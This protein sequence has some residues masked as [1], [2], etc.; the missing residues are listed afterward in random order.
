MTV[1]TQLR[2]VDQWWPL[3]PEDDKEKSS[4]EGKPKITIHTG[5]F[6]HRQGRKKGKTAK[7]KAKGKSKPKKDK[8]ASGSKV[9]TKAKRRKRLS[10][11]KKAAA[12][13]PEKVENFTRKGTGRSLVKQVMARARKLDESKFGDKRLFDPKTDT[14]RLAIG[15]CQG[16]PWSSILD[17]A[18][19]FFKAEFPVC[20]DLNSIESVTKDPNFI[21][22]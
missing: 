11:A 14:C 15:G 1:W 18:H 17:S 2:S 6:L 4:K 10:K 22:V 12:D 13:V 3:M 21:D 19:T 7:A 8:K 9:E 16:Q 5:L 20:R